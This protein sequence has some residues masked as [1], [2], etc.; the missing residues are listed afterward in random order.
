MLRGL[1]ALRAAWLSRPALCRQISVQRDA[2]GV[3]RATMEVQG[4]PLTLEHGRVAPMADCAVM[5]TF[6]DTT[7]LVTAVSTPI[8]GPPP[9]GLP[10]T[11]DYREMFF[12]SGVI[13]G[14]I[15][16]KE[17]ACVGSLSADRWEGES[18]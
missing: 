4:K 12:A 5:A 17:S 16:R 6:G 9:D 10:L 13:P 18:V 8:D 11:V 7:L 2:R 14:S 3:V 15:T 1:P